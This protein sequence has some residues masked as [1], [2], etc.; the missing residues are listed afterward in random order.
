MAA[1]A[2]HP[3]ASKPSCQAPG[4]GG[5]ASYCDSGNS[6]ATCLDKAYDQNTSTQ[7]CPLAPY[8]DVDGFAYNPGTAGYNTAFPECS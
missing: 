1:D 4:G 8:V 3:V 2:E 5:G 6:Y 7:V